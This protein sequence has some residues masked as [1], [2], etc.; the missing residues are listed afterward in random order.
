MMAKIS[1]VVLGVLFSLALPGQS[2]S[3]ADDGPKAE[4]C[5]K[6]FVWNEQTSKCDK[7]TSERVPDKAITDQ[8]WLWAYAGDYTY[9]IELFSEVAAKGDPSALNGMGYSH[10]KLGKTQQAIGYY[11][12]ALAIDPNYL[13]ARNYLAKGYLAMGQ[14]E[15]ALQQLTEIGKRCTAPC[16]LYHD[17]KSAIIVADSGQPVT[18]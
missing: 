11:E 18:Y 5:S 1:T 13:L 17:L 3:A 14:M 2:F 15:P 7:K 16:Q 4:K 10:R 12:Q 8:A 9:A 6:G